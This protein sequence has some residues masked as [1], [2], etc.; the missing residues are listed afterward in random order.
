MGDLPSLEKYVVQGI[1]NNHTKLTACLE[2][3]TTARTT[4]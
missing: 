4:T 2:G 3:K 1:E